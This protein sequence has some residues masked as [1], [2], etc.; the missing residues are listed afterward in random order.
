MIPT[1]LTG[2]EQA[3]QSHLAVALGTLDSG[4]MEALDIL[5]RTGNL[6]NDR[7]DVNLAQAMSGFDPYSA[8][9]GEAAK[10]LAAYSG[11]SGAPA[12][13]QAFANFQASPYQKFME[14]QGE[15]TLLRNAAARGGIGGG[16]LSKD[17][18][19]FGQGNASQFLADNMNLLTSVADRGMTAT[20]QQS[21]ILQNKAGMTSGLVK[22]IG[23]MG[24]N[25]RNNKAQVASGMQYD[26]GNNLAAGRTR[27]GERLADELS[28]TSSALASLY[29]QEGKTVGGIVN[30]GS[31]NLASLIANYG[32][33]TSAIQQQLATILA[34]IS[35]GQASNV[36]GLPGIPGVQ[37]EDGMLGDIANV[38]AAAGG[39]G[40]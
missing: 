8:G 14:E 37:Q 20:G 2:S 9:G 6:A 1:G 39:L 40:G 22:D 18:I 28:S 7:I 10:L 30:Q 3:L 23:T 17:L 25:L 34:N 13:A 27:V 4:S 19:R 31:G 24:A 16:N 36:A 32:Q 33:G 29:D 15:K 26:T 12:Q 21:G 38:I 11:A 5:Q 35:Q